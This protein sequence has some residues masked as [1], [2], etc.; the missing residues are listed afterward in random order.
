MKCFICKQKE[1]LLQNGDCPFCDEDDKC[2]I[3]EDG[4]V[5]VLHC[6]VCDKE[7]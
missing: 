3:C 1:Y 5:R 4:K 2:G 7:N 6:P